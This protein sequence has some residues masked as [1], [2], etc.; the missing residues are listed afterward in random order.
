MIRPPLRL[1][2]SACLALLVVAACDGAEVPPSTGPIGPGSSD[3][4]REV[5]I[6]ARDYAFSP[7]VV[8][9]VPGETVLVHVINGGL[10]VHEA[11]IGDADVQTA[12]EL[13]EAA[14]ADHPPGPTPAVSVTPELAGLR[15]VVESG[16]RVD[17]TWTVPADATG[18][19]FV[20]CHIPGHWE[21]GM[22]VPVRLGGGEA[23]SRRTV[24]SGGTLRA[25]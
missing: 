4:P 19:W 7:P 10:E 24:P 8:D 6:V 14:V 17:V 2:A 22:V 13:A 21:K 15:V 3:A 16:E 20:G 11:V 9:L 23:R 12:W 18:A 25:Y 1:V 5:N